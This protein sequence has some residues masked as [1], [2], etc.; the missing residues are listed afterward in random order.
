MQT[1]KRDRRL[2]VNAG[3]SFPTCHANARLLDCDKSS[4]NVTSDDAAVTCGNCR[5][6][7]AARERSE[8]SAHYEER[9]ES[10]SNMERGFA[11]SARLRSIFEGKR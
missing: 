9:R 10:E 11:S 4:W 5:R 7:I 3:M 1:H 2:Y 6:I 8:V